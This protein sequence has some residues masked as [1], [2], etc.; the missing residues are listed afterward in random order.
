MQLHHNQHNRH[1]LSS[2]FLVLSCSV[3]HNSVTDNCPLV[4]KCLNLNHLQNSL[5]VL[6]EINL[7]YVLHIIFK[8]TDAPWVFNLCIGKLIAS[9]SSHMPHIRQMNYSVQSVTQNGKE[10][11]TGNYL[12]V[13]LKIFNLYEWNKSHY[14]FHLCVM[15]LTWISF[16]C[17]IKQYLDEILLKNKDILCRFCTY[18]TAP[19]V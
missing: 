14:K 19:L 15:F 10:I 11:N 5:H 9:D 1:T 7:V 8:R 13:C 6:A 4:L 18:K 16:H 3:S 17:P 12:I 2:L